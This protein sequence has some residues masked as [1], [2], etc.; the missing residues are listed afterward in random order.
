MGGTAAPNLA[1]ILARDLAATL[2]TPV[3]LVDA[4]GDIV[5]FNE[6]A[7]EVLGTTFAEAQVMTADE[8]SVAFRPRDE[9]GRPLALEELPIGVALREG[10]PAHRAIEI[11]GRDGVARRIEATAVPLRARA[12][13]LVGAVAVFWER[14]AEPS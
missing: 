11:V 13:E 5:F 3:F 12:G 1:L 2:S 7:E 9:G 14:P 4:R 10:R 8:W 6:A